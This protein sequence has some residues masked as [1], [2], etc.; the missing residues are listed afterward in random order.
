VLDVVFGP[1]RLNMTFL[2]QY[3]DTVHVC[4]L[5]TDTLVVRRYIL[6]S[7]RYVTYYTLASGLFPNCQSLSFITVHSQFSSPFCT[8]FCSCDKV[9]LKQEVR[10]HLYLLGQI[11]T[12]QSYP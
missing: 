9:Y 8:L 3:P 12:W 4:Y 7:V 6:I 1:G 5:H 11:V 2:V 10:I